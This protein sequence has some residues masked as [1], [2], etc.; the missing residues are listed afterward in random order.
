GPHLVLG[1]AGGQLDQLRAT[2]LLVDGE[3]RQVGNQHVHHIGPGQRQGAFVQELGAAVLVDVLHDH[4]DLLHAGDEVH[5]PAHA[6]HHLAGDGPVGEVAVLGHLHGAQH[7]HVD[8]AAADHG[9]AVGAREEAGARQAVYGL[10]AGVDQVRIDLVII[11]EGPYAQHAVLALQ[12]HVHAVRNVV[13][14]Q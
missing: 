3:H 13:G 10:L 4:H 12:R 1:D 7:G 11:G 6:L 5:G 9:E 2:G 8:M 14:H